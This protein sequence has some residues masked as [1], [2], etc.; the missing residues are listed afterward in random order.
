M[1]THSEKSAKKQQ[2]SNS[3]CNNKESKKN[4]SNKSKIKT[5]GSKGQIKDNRVGYNS[6]KDFRAERMHVRNEY[7]SAYQKDCKLVFATLFLLLKK[8]SISTLVSLTRLVRQ[9]KWRHLWELSR[10]RTLY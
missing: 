6:E 1:E 9:R 2:G 4:S 7:L 5:G 10:Q 3:H 8:V